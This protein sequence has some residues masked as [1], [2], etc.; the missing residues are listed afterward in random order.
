[1][2]AQS[3]VYGIIGYPV[4]HSLSPLMH[5]TAFKEL[6]VDAVYKLFPLKENE[7]DIFLYR[8]A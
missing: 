5:N 2:D 6:G 8:T 7:L 1:M 3:A 4:A